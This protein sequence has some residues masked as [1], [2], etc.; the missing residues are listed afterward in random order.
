MNHSTALALF[1][2]CLIAA[3]VLAT[4]ITTPAEAIAVFDETRTDSTKRAQFCRMK[5]ADAE[6]LAAYKS[7]D[8][9]TMLRTTKEAND[10]R[11]KLARYQEAFTWAGK[12]SVKAENWGTPETIAINKAQDALRDSCTAAAMTTP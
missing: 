1:A 8:K 2:A 9:P 3:P 4:P 10:L 7:G 11:K 5:T 6:S 12:R